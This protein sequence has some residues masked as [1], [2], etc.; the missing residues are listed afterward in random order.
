M[1]LTERKEERKSSDC[2]QKEE[3]EPFETFSQ[4]YKMGTCGSAK[5]LFLS[6]NLPHTWCGEANLEE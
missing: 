6:M 3:Y 2:G 4:K 1:D 5:Y